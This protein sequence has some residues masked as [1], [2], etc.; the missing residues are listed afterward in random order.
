MKIKLIQWQVACAFAF[1][2]AHAALAAEPSKRMK[3]AR[4]HVETV[5]ATNMTF[6]VKMQGTNVT[7]HYTSETRFFLNGMP[8]VSKDLETA[9]HVSGVLR[10]T[11]VGEPVA[12]RLNIVK[13]APK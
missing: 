7:V 2:I 6:V 11:Q 3:L 10:Q 5:N 8:A 1:I 12:L 9:D 4:T 13:L